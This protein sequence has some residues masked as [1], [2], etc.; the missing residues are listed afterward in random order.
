MPL[1]ALTKL[2]EPETVAEPPSGGSKLRPE[3]APLMQ[4]ATPGLRLPL[5]ET[6]A[7][8]TLPLP[9]IV[10][11]KDARPSMSGLDESPCW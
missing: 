7:L 3:R 6:L 11:L 10:R 8:D 9:L 4:L 1:F 2:K 5:G